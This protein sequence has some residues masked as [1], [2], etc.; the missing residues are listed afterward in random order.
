MS[1][2]DIL[3]KLLTTPGVFWPLL[4][5]NS[6]MFCAGGYTVWSLKFF[7]SHRSMVREEDFHKH[8]AEFSVV[9][10]LVEA[11]RVRHD[12]EIQKVREDLTQRIERLNEDVVD[13]IESVR[14][15]VRDDIKEM[16]SILDKKSDLIHRSLHDFKNFVQQY[17][18][19]K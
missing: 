13:K 18:V 7:S 5:T 16:F 3:V 11:N 15:E 10:N 8:L 17:V 14:K 6:L 4:F 12:A 1:S 2:I 9:R 19:D